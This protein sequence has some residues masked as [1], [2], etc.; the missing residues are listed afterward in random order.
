MRHVVVTLLAGAALLGA[1][2]PL[3]ADTGPYLV[4]GVRCYTFFGYGLLLAGFVLGL[5][6]LAGVVRSNQ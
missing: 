4:E 5:R 2:V 3:V 1:I 6:A